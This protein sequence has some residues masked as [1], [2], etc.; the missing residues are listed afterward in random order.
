MIKKWY[1]RPTPFVILSVIVTI[2]LLFGL[3]AERGGTDGWRY[4]FIHSLL[5]ALIIMLAIDL[6]L[7]WVI[8]KATKW[9]WIIEA[10]LTLGFVYWWI[11][12]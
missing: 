12:T 1:S 4:L 5:P 11:V 7:K 8:K 10:I 3:L 2:V 9:I 6:L